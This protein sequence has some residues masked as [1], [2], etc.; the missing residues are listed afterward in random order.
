MALKINNEIFV[1]RK[2]SRYI[3][4]YT[5]ENFTMAKRSVSFFEQHFFFSNRLVQF[6]LG[7]RSDKNSNYQLF[8]YCI[9]TVYLIPGFTYEVI[10]RFFSFLLFFLRTFVYTIINFD[11]YYYRCY[12]NYLYQFFTMD[13]VLYRTIAE[14]RKIMSGLIMFLGFSNTYY[15]GATL[16]FYKN[17]F[18]MKI[19]IRY[20]LYRFKLDCE[21]STD[22]EELMIIKKYG[23]QTKV[24]AYTI[25]VLFTLYVTSITSSCVLNVILY[26]FGLLNDNQLTLPLLV[27]NV[28]S[29]GGLYYCLLIYQMIIFYIVLIIGCVTFITYL[30]IIQHACCQFNIII[31]KVQKFINDTNYIRNTIYRKISREEF[32]WIIDLIMRYRKVSELIFQLSITLQSAVKIIEFGIY[33]TGSIFTIY[34]NFYIGQKLLN[35]SNAVFEE[36]TQVPFY[37]CSIETQ[38]LLLFMIVRSMKP[39][40]LSIGGL[41]VSSHEVFVRWGKK[42]VDK[43]KNHFN[44]QS[45]IFQ[46]IQ[47]AFSFAMLYQILTSDMKLQDN[48]KILQ[49]VLSAIA[50]LYT[51]SVTYFNFVTVLYIKRDYEQIN[52]K[53]ELDI[54]EKYTKWSKFYMYVIL[55]F[56]NF[57]I[58]LIIF[59]SIIKLI[60]YIFGI[61]DDNQ[62]TLPISIN[63]DLKLGGLYCS[64]FIYQVIL[65]FVLMTVA[66]FCLFAYLLFVQHACSQ[67]NIIKLKI[68][69][70]F[71]KDQ[72]YIES[73]CYGRTCQEE[74]DWIVDIFQLS[75]ILHN[76]MEMIERCIVIV[77]TIFILYINFYVGQKLLDH[78]NTIFEELCQVPFNNLSIKTQKILLFVITRSMKPCG[79]SIGNI[80]V[81]SH[82]AFSELIQKA[83]SFAMFY[84]LY[85]FDTKL[86]SVMKVF[87]SMIPALYFLYC[88]YK[89]S[90]NLTRMKLLFAHIKLDYELVTDEEEFKIIEKYTKQTKLYVYLLVVLFYLNLIFIT[91]PSIVS[92]AWYIFGTSDDIRLI[93]PFSINNVLHAGLLY[94]ILLIY[95]IFG[96]FAIVTIGSVCYSSY[97]VLIQHVCS[98]FS[99]MIWKIRRPFKS[100]EKNMQN[101]QFNITPQEECDWMIDIIKFHTRIT[102]FYVGQLLINHSNDAFEELCN[103]PFYNLSIRTQKLLLFLLTRSIKPIELSIGGVFVAS[104]VVYA[105]FYQLF[106]SDIKSLL[107][108]DLLEKILGALSIKMIF[109]HVKFDYEQLCGDD[110]FEIMDKYM[111]ESKLY[112]TIIVGICNLYVISI[113]IPSVFNVI[114]HIFGLLDDI[115]LTLPLP[116]NNVVNAGSLYYSLLIYQIIA[117]FIILTLACVSYS[118]Y[119]IFVQHACIQFSLIVLTIR[120]PFKYNQDYIEMTCYSVTPRDEINWIVDII[121]RYSRITELMF[122]L[123]TV[124]HN[125]NK[126]VEYSAAIAGSI[127]TIYINFY[128]GQLLIN[129]SYEAFQE[130]CQVPFYVLSI[131]TQKM[132]LFVIAKSMKP[133]EVSIG[134]IF[135]ASHELFAGETSPFQAP[136]PPCGRRATDENCGQQT[137]LRMILKNISARYNTPP[138]DLKYFAMS[139][140]Y[141]CYYEQHFLLSN[142]IV[143]FVLGLHPKQCSSDQLFQCCSLAVYILPLILYQFYQ[144]V[145]LDIKL[146]TTC[147][148]L[149]KLL[150][151]LCIT[152]TYSVVYFR[153]STLKK[154][155]IYFKHDYAQLSDK[156]EINICKKHTKRNKLYAIILLPISVILI[157]ACSCYS[158]YLLCVQHACIQF[159]ILIFKIRQPFDQHNFTCKVFYGETRQKEYNWINNIITHYAR[160]TRYVE[161]INDSSKII[162]LVGISFAMI[163][164]IFN[165]LYMLQLSVIL[166]SMLINHNKATFEELCNVPFYMLS[167][168]TQKM[169]LFTIAR[170][171]RPCELSI[172]G[173]IVLL[174]LHFE[175]EDVSYFAMSLEYRC[176]YEQHFL[177]SNRIV[178]LVLGLHPKQCSSDQLFQCCSLAVYILPL[179][180]YQFYQ[181]AVWDIK[182]QTTCNLLPKLLG[183]LCITCTY[184]VVYF[185]FSTI[186]KLVI[187]FKHDYAQLSDKEEINIC[188][189]HTKRNKLYA[190]ILLHDN[191]QLTLPFPVNNVLKAGLLYYCLLIYEIIGI[192]LILIIACS[193]YSSYLIFVQHACIQFSILI[194]K[195]RQPFYQHNFTRKVF[196]GESRQKEYNWIN[197]IVAHYARITKYVELINHSSKMLQLSVILQSVSETIECGFTICVSLFGIYINFHVGQMLINHNKATFEEL[198]NVPFYMLSTKTQK[199]LLFTIARSMRPCELS[200]AG[201][202]VASHEIYAAETSGTLAMALKCQFYC[203]RHFLLSNRI[204]QLI[205]GLHPSQNSTNQFLQW[206]AIVIYLIPMIA[207]QFYQLSM[208]N[209]KLQSNFNLLQKVLSA[210]CIL[211]TYG[212][213]YFRSATIKKLFA[214]HKH[215]YEQFS[216][217]KEIYIYQKYT[218]KNKLYTIV[219]IGFCYLYAFSLTIPS[220]FNVLRY[221]IESNEDVQLTLP[222]PVNNVYNAGLLFKIGQPFNEQKYKKKISCNITYEEEW[223]WIVDVIKRYTTTME[224]VD[225]INS[226]SKIIYLVEISFAMILIFFDLLYMLQLSTILQ[227][228]DGIFEC[229]VITIGSVLTIY[230][231]FYIGQMLINHNKEAFEELYQV[232]FYMLSVN[233]QKLLLFTISRS[234]RPCEISIGG[235]FVASNE[236]FSGLIQKAFSFAMLYHTVRSAVIKIS[237]VEEA[238]VFVVYFTVKRVRQ[239]TMS[240]DG[241]TYFERHFFYSNKIVQYV[242]GIRPNQTSNDLLFQLCTIIAYTFPTIVHQLATSDITLHL[243]VKILQ[244]MM[245]ATSI[246]CTYSTSYFKS[247]QVRKDF[248]YLKL[249]HSYIKFDYMRLT[250]QDEW[251]I[252]EKYKKQ[253]KKYI[254][255]LIGKDVTY[256][257]YAIA[258]IFP[259]ILNIFIYLF[260]TSNDVHLKLPFPINGVSKPGPLYYSLFIYQAI[261]INIIMTLGSVIYSSYLILV[262]HACCQFSIIR[263]KV[264]QPFQ[265]EQKY[266]QKNWLNDK[267][268]MEFEW[269]VDI[270]K[271]HRRIFELS[272]FAKDQI[273]QNANELIECFIYIAGSIFFTYI[274][275]G[276]GQ[277]LMDHNE[278]A[279]KELCDVPFYR[280]SVKTQK[281]LFLAITRSMKPCGLSIGDLFLSSHES[282]SR[283]M[284]K[285][286]SFATV[287]YNVRKSVESCVYLGAIFVR[288]FNMSVTSG[289]TYYEQHF[290]YSNK[291]CQYIMGLRPYQSSNDLLFQVCTVTAYVL[292]TIAHQVNV[293]FFLLIHTRSQSLELLSYCRLFFFFYQLVML[294]V[295]LESFVKVLQ[296][297]LS[298]VHVIF[299]QLTAL[300]ATKETFENVEIA[301]NFQIK[302]IYSQLKHDY[303]HASSKDELEI[304]EEYNKTGKIYTYIIVGKLVKCY[305]EIRR[306]VFYF[307]F[308]ATVTPYLLNVF[309]YHI[310]T[311]EN[312]NFTLPIPVNNVSN[313]GAIYYTLLIYQILGIYISI[314]IGSICFSTYLAI[315]Q[316][317]CCQLRI[318]RLK[319]G[320]PFRDHQKLSQMSRCDEMVWDEF[321]WFVD[322]IEHYRRATKYVLINYF[323]HSFGDLYYFFFIDLYKFV[324][325]LNSLSKSMYLIV[326]CIVMILIVLDMLYILQLSTVMKNKWDLIECTTYVIG[327]IFITYINMYL[328]QMLINHSIETHAEL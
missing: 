143:Q 95:Q 152:C 218:K 136:V 316:H 81:S 264:R 149:P 107:T 100:N 284:Q 8:I 155:V 115:H 61:L 308:I 2:G 77:D 153:F 65:I 172:G 202:F 205:L 5:V 113:T 324:D 64:F 327:S 1:I 208:A 267:F 198:C 294:D 238:S 297:M 286:F 299:V 310:G 270:I 109:A 20:L 179:I 15:Y 189:K 318:I 251:N 134:G 71:Q 154:L 40:I 176:Y 243:V 239:L 199:M 252:F 232:P 74:Y 281:L 72:E 91:C 180:L 193:C 101:T 175:A 273:L 92:V 133:C 280:L 83:L 282:F 263:L 234:M 235:I 60:F 18:F 122:Q 293:F 241:V 147:N 87:E 173:R 112:I 125:T 296:K 245:A 326:M 266:V 190:I 128:V 246:L 138:E 19:H 63:N 209:L 27:N 39:C 58:F 314:T 306:R 30:V 201:I 7:L 119:W 106:T 210:S 268:R 80:F 260:G 52:D 313:P 168:K 164:I 105:G 322:V 11:L 295:T 124:L 298:V 219:F 242:M 41:F 300:Y 328:G 194:F 23:K 88:Y 162:Y 17:A 148:L 275:Y 25:V 291:F 76:A 174:V 96:S 317:A 33:I 34:I 213:V 59:P 24:Y 159:S 21:Q 140:E 236:I 183:A 79:L 323:C 186:K 68:R 118:S 4:Y 42:V 191:V 51:Y 47:K 169:L 277:K 54:F 203:E 249:I 240:V 225:L 82:E 200:I 271:R 89:I 325:L 43:Q 230:M 214:Y 181:L 48:V 73:P 247:V 3:D 57:Y 114:L 150:G 290:L 279:L 110:Q 320:Q 304:I 224:F 272:S 9:V 278:D 6:M 120:K 160:I 312:V 233:T 129:H 145:V 222:L 28:P 121:K 37:M 184:S 13:F 111:K 315:V 32:N 45:L 36:L 307:Y 75:E 116:V 215:D 50:I 185:R 69:Q 187:Y 253:S 178:Q 127:F 319:L 131:K 10:V 158:S 182:L 66:G 305:S 289:L 292:P 255:C 53:K 151:A 283:L 98:Q 302:Q 94:Y 31:W 108:A 123:S 130:L 157:I 301:S 269:I 85:M 117:I 262:Q 67:F 285:A 248:Y 56:I 62:L 195:I 229:F 188:K 97:W 156:E 254:Y 146:Q 216:D 227:N 163:L 265:R 166:Q 274:L 197:N 287:Y 288:Y 14:L 196:Y 70:P 211:C 212:A 231:N 103:I 55:V 276:F 256:I 22:K 167:T 142:R 49:R 165:V 132:L 141:R 78:G 321:D 44:D 217:E 93:L 220:V 226:S 29:A 261:G 309:S 84:Q 223:E 144:L 26:L 104:H 161:L 12:Y 102:N 137:L 221:I 228:T 192:F 206:C 46:L 38:K 99:I 90:V 257:F 250:D 126:L 258:M 35:Y 170:S 259:R 207:H 244:D 171:M 237:N 135:V 86:Q 16:Y 139:L 204:V 303:T 177:L 311:T